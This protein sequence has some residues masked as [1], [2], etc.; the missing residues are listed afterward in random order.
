MCLVLYYIEFFLD[1]SLSSGW[2]CMTQYTLSTSHCMHASTHSTKH[3]NCISDYV[4]PVD[5]EC[6]PCWCILIVCTKET[7]DAAVNDMIWRLAKG[8]RMLI[9][10]LGWGSPTVCNVTCQYQETHELCPFPSAHHC[11]F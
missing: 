3:C 6:H 7:A 4:S 9:M 10:L 8:E 2:W 5:G 1:K 11:L